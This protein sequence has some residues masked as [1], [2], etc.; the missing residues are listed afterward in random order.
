MIGLGGL[1]KQLSKEKCALKQSRDK[2]KEST[3]KL[4]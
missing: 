1:G 4:R 2:D 3:I